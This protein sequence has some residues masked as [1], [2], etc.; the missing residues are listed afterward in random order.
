LSRT[1]ILYPA[2]LFAAVL[3]KPET[4]SRRA[5]QLIGGNGCEHLLGLYQ[6][7]N[8]NLKRQLSRMDVMR[9]A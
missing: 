7:Q 1:A 4:I 9:L 6:G 2:I 3:F 8:D 5:L